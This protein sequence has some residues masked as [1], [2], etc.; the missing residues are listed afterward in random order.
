MS[1]FGLY[2]FA[3]MA[4]LSG[5]AVDVSNLV[6]ARSQLQVTADAAAHAALYERDSLDADDAKNAA[7]AIV[8]D[9]MPAAKFG[10]VLTT[11]DI[12][13]GRWDYASSEFEVDPD[14]REAVMVRTA[15]LQ[16][17]SNPVTSF[18]MQFVGKQ[19]WDVATNAVYTTYRPTCFRE[20]F[21]AEGVVD[22]QSNNGFSNGFC[23]HSNSYVSMNNNN[24]FEP[25][26]IVSMP[27]SSLIDLPNSGWEKNE[28]LAATLREGAYRLRI[29]N[30]LEEIIE[31][32][33][34]NDSRYRPAYVTKTGVFNRS[35]SK[36]SQSDLVSNAVN[37]VTCGGSGKLTIQGASISNVV[38]V[39]ACQVTL[40]NNLQVR[41]AIIAT[42]STS[43]K[44]IS[45]SSGLV[46]GIDDSCAEGGGSQLLTL[47]SM[48]FAADLHI[49][50]SQ[51]LAAGDIEFA[52]D[53]D[54]VEGASM[55]AGGTSAGRQT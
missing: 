19:N 39:T 54:G 26:T 53:A 43:S 5:I 55:I 47:G 44:S 36:I 23:L 22:I 16:E 28:G 29:I 7:L 25:G 8:E 33:K 15:R 41:D 37:Y 42:T 13:F 3:A 32:L 12:T 4:I 1:I 48:N 31:S 45:S 9:M 27:D 24:F 10:V 49:Y 18:L 21:V 40:A 34:V 50:G 20:G 46:V 38:I 30:K 14:S 2:I 52:A 11:D 35:L 51:L 6:S 17:T